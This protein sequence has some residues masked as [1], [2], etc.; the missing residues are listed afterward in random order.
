[1]TQT[2]APSLA[3]ARL[4]GPSKLDGKT[5]VN[6]NPVMTMNQPLPQVRTV[7][8]FNPTLC[9]TGVDHNVPEKPGLKDVLDLSRI[10]HPAARLKDKNSYNS[11]HADVLQVSPPCPC[12]H[13]PLFTNAPVHSNITLHVTPLLTRSRVARIPCL[14]PHERRHGKLP[15]GRSLV[16]RLPRV[17]ARPA[18]RQ[19]EGEQSVEL[20]AG[21]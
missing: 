12:S 17:A 9:S 15:G 21:E 16:P 2:N 5:V 14:L 1:M 19:H 4:T 3:Y 8:S 10:N 13:M 7:N 20:Q 6:A 18:P 11:R